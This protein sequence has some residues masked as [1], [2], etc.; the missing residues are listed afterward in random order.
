MDAVE[1]HPEITAMLRRSLPA[2]VHTT[3]ARAHT[4]LLASIVCLAT[5]VLVEPTSMLVLLYTLGGAGLWISIKHDDENR[6]QAVDEYFDRWSGLPLYSA[7]PYALADDQTIR[8]LSGRLAILELDIGAATERT[9]LGDHDATNAVLAAV[10][11]RIQAHAWAESIHGPFGALLFLRRPGTLVILRRDVLDDS[12]SRWLA[13]RL[14][15]VLNQPIEWRGEQINPAISVAIA[16][17]AASRATALPTLLAQNRRHTRQRPAGAV[18]SVSLDNDRRHQTTSPALVDEDGALIGRHIQAEISTNAG[19][20]ESTAGLLRAVGDALNDGAT[21]NITRF[22][23]VSPTS[24][25]HPHAVSEVIRRMNMSPADARLGIILDTSFP[26]HPSHRAVMAVQQLHN[27]GVTVFAEQVGD[28]R[29]LPPCPIE[30]VVADYQLTDAADSASAPM[31]GIAVITRQTMADQDPITFPQRPSNGA[32][33][34]YYEG[35][36]AQLAKASVLAVR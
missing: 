6:T 19:L 31:Q 9:Q 29:A 34:L 12:T 8:S 26:T 22:V 15:A 17:G 27:C 21:D 16:Q 14:V 2:I 28:S 23:T 4:L 1:A 33:R 36:S 24:L 10:S 7:L 35:Q 13:K 32:E 18:D 30:G 3:W 25:I 11:H 20:F 5:S